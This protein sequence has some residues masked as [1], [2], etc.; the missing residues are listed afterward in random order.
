L[1]LALACEAGEGIS[2]CTNGLLF[3]RTILVV[4]LR[5]FSDFFF[6]SAGFPA[7]PKNA[8]SISS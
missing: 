4:R 5:R 3:C 7:G 8:F 1:G 6:E 2:K